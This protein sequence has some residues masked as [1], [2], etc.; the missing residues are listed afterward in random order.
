MNGRPI[1]SVLALALVL[2]ASCRSG[3][4]DAPGGGARARDVVPQFAHSASADSMLSEGESTYRRGEYDSAKVL[5]VGGQRVALAA[6]DSAAVARA[7][8]WLGLAAWKKAEYEDARLVGERALQMKLRLGLKRDLFRSYNALGLLAHAEGRLSDAAS[9]FTKA[10]SAAREVNDSVS[11]AKALGNLGLVHADAGAFDLARSEF[12]TLRASAQRTGDSV[13]EGNALANLGMLEVRSGDATAAIGWLSLAR[14]AY[15]NPDPAQEEN[16]LGHLGTAYSALGDAQRAIAYIDSALNVARKHDLK[17]QEAEDLQVFAELLGEAGDHQRALE[18]LNRARTVARLIGADGR[19]GEI[20]RSRAREL[21]LISRH[22]LARAAARDAINTHRSEG[23]LLEELRD[24]LLL[25]EIAQ[26]SRRSSEAQ[27]ALR[28]ADSLSTLLKLDIA[29]ENVA[30]GRARVGDLANDAAGVLRSLPAQETF[31]RMGPPA[32]GEAHALRARAFAR[33][34]QWPEAVSSGR[35][36]LERL[37]GIRQKIGEGPLRT[38]FVSEQSAVYADLVIAL[39]RLGRTSEAFEVADAARGKSLLEHIVAL[40][41]EASTTTADLA[42]SE[43]LLRR[44]DWL[45]ERLRLADTIS[46]PDRGGKPRLD[47]SD[48]ASRLAEARHDYE[49]RIKR[50][51]ARDPRSAALLG[52]FGPRADVIRASLAPGELLLEYMATPS[53]LHIFAATRDTIAWAKSPATL[54]QLAPRVRLAVELTSRKG[55]ASRP[56][57]LRALYDLLIRPIAPIVSLSRFTSLVIVPHSVL[58]H[59]PFAALVA[60]SGRYLVEDHSILFLPSASALPY[61]RN[62]QVSAGDN[63]TSIFAPF[64]AELPGSRVE[65]LAVKR[66]V[67]RPTSYLGDLATERRLRETFARPGIVHIASHAQVNHANPM[68]SHVELARGTPGA[69]ADDGRFEVHELLGIA[70]KSQLVFLSGCETA[71]GVAWSTSFRRAHDYATLS[72]AF[73]YSGARDVVATLWRIDDRGASTFASRFYRELSARPA[74]E[75]LAM[76]QR[77]M[78]RDSVYSSPRYWA[79]Y[80]LAGRGGTNRSAQSLRVSSVK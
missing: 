63:K 45:T 12:K 49:D 37:E 64:P 71:A 35:Q 16:V 57:V 43:Q 1:R 10:N 30:L 2:G 62:E 52:V 22:D 14:K 79:A 51:S 34:G 77:A 13:A 66:V 29:R 20:E 33:L 8:T 4:Q 36:A 53:G 24:N 69:T 67:P 9:L 70:V 28:A 78:I 40:G 65:A 17:L 3:E 23:F 48:L 47:L 15:G 32:Q 6:G 59:L 61:L 38:S 39:L 50:V 80:T 72:Q 26:T 5:L 41:R 76:A 27:G 31:A 54:E 75:A 19:G 11:I 73:L 46:A 7:L 55:A 58:A 21:A 42:E 25:A 18:H 68:F 56:L 74:A 60:P 44:I